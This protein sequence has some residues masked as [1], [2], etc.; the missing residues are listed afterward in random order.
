M[1]LQPIDQVPIARLVDPSESKAADPGHPPLRGLVPPAG[2][3]RLEVDG[4]V[5]DWFQPADREF[6]EPGPVLLHLADH[7]PPTSAVAEGSLG[8]VG[9]SDRALVEA[10][11]VP[12]LV[13]RGGGCWWLDVI[14]PSFHPTSPPLAFLVGAC[15][16]ELVRAAG[17]GSPVIAVSG[18]GVGGQGALGLAYRHPV[19]F[20]VVAVV[21]PILDFHLLMRGDDLGAGSLREAFQEVED[22]RQRTPILHVHPLNWPRHQCI[23]FDP[24]RPSIATGVERLRGKLAALGIPYELKTAGGDD[25]IAAVSSFVVDRSGSESRRLVE[26]S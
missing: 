11:G 12:T 24:W 6:G 10:V 25:A 8:F 4:R 22:A 17:G 9:P 16:S 1:P 3:S 5:A 23:A 7:M 15:R 13:P 19:L 14:E 21:D 26:P 18:I 20:P 2:W